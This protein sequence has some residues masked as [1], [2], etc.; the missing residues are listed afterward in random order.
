MFIKTNTGKMLGADESGVYD[1]YTENP[2][3]DRSRATRIESFSATRHTAQEAY[4]AVEDLCDG[5]VAVEDCELLVLTGTV[6]SNTQGLFYAQCTIERSQPIATR[7]VH[8]RNATLRGRAEAL[9]ES[10]V[11]VQKYLDAGLPVPTQ[12][13]YD[14]LL[15][16][17]EGDAWAG[18]EEARMRVANGH[19]ADNG[20]ITRGDGLF[21]SA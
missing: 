3:G 12:A 20:I 8:M 19:P 6:R 15:N 16:N 4:T 10:R 11:P 9:A 5:F 18:Q 1:F 2:N 14:E 7:E 13:Q 17:P 21:E